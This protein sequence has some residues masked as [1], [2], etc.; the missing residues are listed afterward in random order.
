MRNHIGART[1][2]GKVLRQGYYWPTILKDATDLVKK[3]RICKKHAKISRLPSEPLTSITSP[4]PFQH[5][6]LDILG[7]LPIGKGQC[8]FIIVAVDYFTKWAEA[9]PLA[10]ITEQ[11]I[12]NFVWRA[13]ICRFGIPR[14]LVSNNGKQF[15]NAKFRDFCAELGIKNYYSSPAH[16][17]SNGQAE[18]TIR[19]LKAALKTK[20]EDLKGSWVEYLPEVLWAY[21]TTHKSASR[22][23]PFALAFGTE[24]V[25]PVEV[26]IKSPRVELASEEHNDEALRLNLELLDEKHEQ[27][28]RRTEEDNQV[29]QPESQ[30]QKLHA[31]GLS[32]KE[33]P[34]NKKES[35][36]WEAR[37][38]LGRSL[39]NNPSRQTRQLRTPNK[40]GKNLAAHVECGTS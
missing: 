4:W 37:P 29:L 15:D 31:G 22:E 6:G 39:H 40:R 35:R 36:A 9:E 33:A 25:A 26:G 30:A 5:W 1:L 2:A 23:T 8:K 12:R 14:A 34:A 16:P 10:T 32:L 20:L 27:V 19:T 17:Q 38:Q 24:A 18:V 11:K 7:P 13:I 28:Q 3:C 21:R